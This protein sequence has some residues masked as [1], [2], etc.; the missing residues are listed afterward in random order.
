MG[1]SHTTGVYATCLDCLMEKGLNEKFKEKSPESA[2]NI[3]AWYDSPKQTIN[4]NHDWKY[5]DK[6][7]TLRICK[8]C[9][10]TEERC[11]PH[12]TWKPLT[13]ELWDKILKDRL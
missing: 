10:V 2:K 6:N 4:C 11:I 8:S 13:R 12:K 3:E 7:K 5:T 1:A 9:E